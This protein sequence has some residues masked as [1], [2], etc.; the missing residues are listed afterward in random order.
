MYP[1]PAER[2]VWLN[3]CLVVATAVPILLMLKTRSVYR[4]S[5][6]D[7]AGATAAATET[8]SGYQPL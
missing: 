5:A 7:S 6:V 4:R 2:T 1:P 8:V 3:Y